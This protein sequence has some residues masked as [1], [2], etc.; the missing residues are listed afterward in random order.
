MRNRAVPRAYRRRSERGRCSST[1]FAREARAAFS[2]PRHPQ[3]IAL[4]LQGR[5]PFDRL[6]KFYSLGQINEALKD[7]EQ[8]LTIKP[9]I[10]MPAA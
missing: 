2:E 1:R 3:L 5:F 8:G 6:V 10:R 9:I 7:S 4:Y